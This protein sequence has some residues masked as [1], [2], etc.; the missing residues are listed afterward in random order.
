MSVVLQCTH[1][2]KV[3]LGLNSVRQ[4]I[5]EQKVLDIDNP[6]EAAI[7]E[8]QK[9]MAEGDRFA[10]DLE[11]VVLADLRRKEKKDE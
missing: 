3:V 8:L 11:I 5:K 1:Q 4:E 10:S 2:A 9:A 7:E 6:H